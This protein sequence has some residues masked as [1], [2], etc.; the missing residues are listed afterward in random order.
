MCTVFPFLGLSLAPLAG[1]TG[2]FLEP[3]RADVSKPQREFNRHHDGKCTGDVI[4]IGFCPDFIA[5]L[6]A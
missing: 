1:R 5:L 3:W 4:P 6:A 2:A